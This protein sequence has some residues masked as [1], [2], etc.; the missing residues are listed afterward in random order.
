[1]VMP[2]GCVKGSRTTCALCGQVTCKCWEETP[3]S[4][5]TAERFRDD[6]PQGVSSRDPWPNED[7]P[8]DNRNPKDIVG[9]TKLPLYLWPV[10]ATAL[11]SLA[12]L[13]GMLKYGRNNWRGKEISF[14]EYIGAL[15]RHTGKLLEGEWTDPSG[16]PH[17]GHILATVAI[18]CDAWA[19]GRLI[20][21]RNY[22]GSEVLHRLAEL[23]PIVGQLRAN[24]ADKSPHHWTIGD[25]RE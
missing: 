17:V 15:L 7:T 19:T 3:H 2:G 1:M 13:D 14:S 20:D 11:G 6:I 12:L 21:D 23:E 9:S 16:V 24:H 22:R 18:I 8:V 10:I 4:V 25:E 5:A